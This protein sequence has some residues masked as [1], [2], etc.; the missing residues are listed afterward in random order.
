MKE[1][2]DNSL[3]MPATYNT[4]LKR[5]QIAQ[6]FCELAKEHTLVC[7]S[8][9]HDQHLQQQGWAAAVAN[10]EDITA[11]FKT[12]SEIFEQNYKQYLENREQN[13]NILQKYV[14]ILSM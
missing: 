5:T 14:P 3:V 13:L 4:V 6:Q 7:E 1:L 10:L 2:V 12:K 8:L 9:V 11:A